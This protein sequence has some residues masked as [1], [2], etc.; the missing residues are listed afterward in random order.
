MPVA[1]VIY[2][3][4]Q[5]S[6]TLNTIYGRN[7]NPQRFERGSRRGRSLHFWG[8]ILLLGAI[9]AALGAVIY[10]F[11]RPPSGFTGEKVGLELLG[12]Q[13]PETAVPVEYIVSVK[14]GED[15]DL[16]DARIFLGWS[17]SSS[18]QSPRVEIS[19]AAGQPVANDQN[20]WSVGALSKGGETR[21]NFTAAF[22]GKEGESV[23][24]PLRLS[25]RPAG[26]NSVFTREFNQEF[27]LGKSKIEFSLSGPDNV[28][29][30]SGIALGLSLNR[31]EAET[32]PQAC[33]E[34]N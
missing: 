31:P 29:S 8:M 9:S 28:S 21:F 30:G 34:L 10:L 4:S 5:F 17:G 22:F 33:S 32:Y 16:S 15:S 6:K 25:F 19:E 7:F 24:L 23:S 1:A 26:F 14:N 18:S 3:N 12:N 11:A 20:T 2:M 27:I 13:R